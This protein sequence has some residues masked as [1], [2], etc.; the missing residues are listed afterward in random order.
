MNTNLIASLVALVK[1]E[2]ESREHA[3][4]SMSPDAAYYHAT[5]HDAPLTNE[6][7]LLV[8]LFMWHK[9]EKEI[10]LLAALSGAKDTSPIA[11]DDYRKKVNRIE[12]LKPEKRR[13]ELEKLAP[14]LDN[15]AWDLLD[16]LRL[17]ANSFKHDPF[18]KPSHLLLKRLGL[19]EK[20]NYASLS[21]SGAI[22]FGLAK[23]LGIG[24][25]AA[26]SEIVDAVR[27]SCDRILFMLQA[28]TP[29]RVF[30]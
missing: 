3:R 26:F 21:E 18:G 4:A 27:K 20:M 19:S 10:V 14:A 2:E 23:F 16:M 5:F 22:R 13:K 12:K 24:E 9:I 6:L 25:D 17:L 15:R 11:R 8:L 28:G 30:E 1:V 7:Y 29:L